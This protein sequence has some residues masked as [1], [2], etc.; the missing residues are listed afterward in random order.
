MAVNT[1][2]CLTIE[3]DVC[4]QD[5]DPDDYTLHF[6]DLTEARDVSAR[7]G[8]TVTADQ[9]VICSL[10]DADHQAAIDALMPP[11]PITQCPGQLGLDGS[12]EV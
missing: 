5:Y 7:A 1:H 2:T 3:C 8:W 9:Q 6:R 12:M 10:G 11:E 4:G